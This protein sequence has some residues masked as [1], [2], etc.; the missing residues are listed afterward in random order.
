MARSYRVDAG[1]LTLFDG[2]GNESLTFEA[3]PSL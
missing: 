2:G 1:R 3:E